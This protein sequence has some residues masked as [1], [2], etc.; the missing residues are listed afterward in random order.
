MKD[1][2]YLLAYLL[3]ASAALGLALQGI[4]SWSTVVFSFAIIPLLEMVFP[5]SGANIPPDEEENRSRRRFFDILLYLNLPLL[6]GLVGWYL[7]VIQYQT[8]TL[9]EM[10][11]LT[12]SAGILVGAVGINVAH[13]LGH[14]SRGYEQLMSKWML[15][16]ALYQHFFI[17]HN[18][19]HHKHVATDLDPA[20][21]RLGEPVFTFWIRSIAGGW[22]NAWRLEQERLQ[23]AGL[24]FWSRQ[25][26]ML[27]FQLWQL[28]WLAVVGLLLGVK[29]L[30]GAI[31]IALIG[32]LLLE[33]INYIEHYG[34]RRRILASGRPEPVT[35]AHSWNSDHELGRIFLYE[36]T[37][38][39]DH[40]Y[41]ASRKY[42]ILRHL[43]ESPQ[44]PFGYPASVLL[45][46]APPLWF[47]V[48]DGRVKV[49]EWAN[50]S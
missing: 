22:R 8:L 23:K 14:R 33:T 45:A 38:H 49:W 1:F 26:E 3:P 43:D 41:K 9:A 27:R 12:L 47:R 6:F 11:G 18:R 44:L 37:R 4:W 31:I 36:L 39:S 28:L 32:I 42:Q 40:H 15:L 2:K 5:Q 20:S 19:G 34:L 30:L 35:P 46:L 16:P 7:Y 21:A 29:A 48:M 50:H 24:P 25:N 13:E 17:E 10:A